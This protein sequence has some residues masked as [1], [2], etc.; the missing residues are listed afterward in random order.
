MP[1]LYGR[2]AMTSKGLQ[3]AIV[4]G[5]GVS[6]HDVDVGDLR[7]ALLQLLRIASIYLN[8]IQGTGFLR[9]QPGKSALARANF[10]DDVTGSEA[11]TL[12]NLVYHE[13]VA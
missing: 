8:G 5:A 13:R 6:V 12:D 10:H 3:E 7:K 11:S 9:Q 2:L 4:I 1:T